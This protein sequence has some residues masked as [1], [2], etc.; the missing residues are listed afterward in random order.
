[1]P[2]EAIA[3]PTT[4]VSLKYSEVIMAKAIINV[5]KREK[6]V[7]AAAALHNINLNTLR[8]RV[9]PWRKH[10]LQYGKNSKMHLIYS[11]T[12]CPTDIK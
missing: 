4:D 7:V 3:V 10:N 12:S 1:M 9:S 11:K 5:V 6:A 8:A 2:Q